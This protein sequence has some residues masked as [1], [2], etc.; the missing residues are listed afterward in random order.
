MSPPR[1]GTPDRLAAPGVRLGARSWAMLAGLCSPLVVDSIEVALVSVALPAM[2]TDLGMSTA[3]MQWI[4]TGYTVGFG[5][6]LLLGGKAADLLG[7][8]RLFLVAVATLMIISAGTAIAPT[9]EILIGLRFL[10]GAGLA[11]ATPVSLSIITGHYTGRARNKALQVYAASAG[12]GVGGGLVLSGLLT[13][14]SWRWAVLLPVPLLIAA[15]VVSYFLIPETGRPTRVSSS[16]DV[17][18]AVIATGAMLLVVLTLVEAPAAGWG[19]ARTLGSLTVAVALVALFIAVEVRASDPLVRLGVLRSGSLVRANLA[20]MSLY[21]AELAFLVISTLYMQQVRRWS[22]L[23]AGLAILPLPV[24]A[25]FAP[26]FRPVLDR[27]G[28]TRT[29]AAGMGVAVVGY[30]LSLTIGTDSGYALTILPTMLL[31]GLAFAL[32]F[33]PLFIAAV[34]DVAPHEHGLA[35]GLVNTSLQ[36]GAALVVATAVA[37]SSTATGTN[38]S[39]PGLLHGYR[40]ALVVVLV[41]AVLGLLAVL[42]G[43]RRASPRGTST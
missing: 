17:A 15:L 42:P 2:R 38:L 20:A 3:A 37:V 16:F 12:L 36:S 11:F 28:A 35:N 31:I 32:A 41:V 14:L 8:R 25:L 39:S 6:F 4:V 22:A 33:G 26:M 1:T 10:K 29:T 5:G 19:S 21:G 13:G 40:V 27:F 23:E 18:G 7:R 34:E 43:L 24:M 9:G 30:A